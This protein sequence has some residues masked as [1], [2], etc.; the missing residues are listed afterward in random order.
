MC[1]VTIVR[2]GPDS[3][4][5]ACNRD[6]SRRRPSALPPSIRDCGQRRAILPI[7]PVG[8]GTWIG[9]NDAGIAATLLNVYESPAQALAPE[10]ALGHSPALSIPT[11][12]KSRGTII[13]ILFSEQSFE[14]AMMRV[15]ELQP[16]DFPPFRLI[17]LNDESLLEAASDGSALRV[18]HCAIG[19]QPRLFTSSG[20]GDAVARES[21]EAQFA[22]MFGA[23]PNWA[24]AQAAFHRHS[25]PQRREISVCMERAEARTVS[26]TLIEIQRDRVIATYTPGAPDRVTAL[27]TICLPRVAGAR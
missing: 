5:L 17:V 24:A 4:R 15:R 10:T 25:W 19:A 13:P 8:G 3:L 2:V 22:E 21:R 23:E 27:P 1:T 26:H 12:F 9:V 6:E 18:N 14:R 16:S 11:G 20:L 7:D